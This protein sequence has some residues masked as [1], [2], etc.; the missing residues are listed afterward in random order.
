VLRDLVEAL[1][2]R[3]ERDAGSADAE[4]QILAKAALGHHL[5]EIPVGR[6]AQG[7]IDLPRDRAPERRDLAQLE[8]AA[9]AKLLTLAPNTGGRATSAVSR[10][11]N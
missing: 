2:Q 8:G 7:K 9:L 3:Q 1:A 4:V 5:P 6:R 10:P 11:G